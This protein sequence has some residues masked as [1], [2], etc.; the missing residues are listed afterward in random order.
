M[1]TKLFLVS[2]FLTIL[3]YAQIP[4]N[5]LVAQYNFDSGATLADGINGTNLTQTGNT[6]TTVTD[7]FGNANGAVSL[8]GAYLTRPDINFDRKVSYSF[9]IK[10]TTV[11]GKQKTIIDNGERTGTSATVSYATHQLGH[12]IALKNGRIEVEANIKQT[13]HAHH[14]LS[15]LNNTFIA[16]GLWHHVVVS[17]RASPFTSSSIVFVYI[18]IDGVMKSDSK[19]ITSVPQGVIDGTNGKISIGT[20]RTNTLT[21]D[22]IYT[23]AIDDINIYNEVLDN[24]DIQDLFLNNNF[25]APPNN[26][27]LTFSNITQNEAKLHFSTG[28]SATYDV[29]YHKASEPFT[30]AI[31]VT[32]VTTGNLPITNLTKN[33]LYKIYI[34]KR[35]TVN[36]SDWSAPKDLR[37]NA[38]VVYVNN[39]A[40][41]NNDGTSWADAFTNLQAALNIVNENSEIWV[42]KGVYKPAISDK[43]ASYTVNKENIKIYGGFTGTENHRWERVR[44]ANETILSGDLNNNDVNT[45]DYAT[46]YSNTTRLE[47]SRHIITIANGGENLLL[48]GLTISNAHNNGNITIQ[49]GAIV[50]DKT[51]A[52]LTLK[53]C[54][55]KNNVSGNG[56]AGVLAEFELNN[57]TGSRGELHIEN[58]QFINN[59]SRWGS[60]IY[61]F[62]RDDTR[63][64]V[65][66]ANS[67]F[68][69]N[70]AGNTTTNILGL[71]GSVAWIRNMGNAN[72]EMNINFTNNTVVKNIDI[73]T[74]NSLS[75]TTRATVALSKNSV[76]AGKS[77]AYVNNNIFWGNTVEGGVIGRSVT[78]L[79]ESPLNVLEIFNSIDQA[80]FNDDSITI[81]G[82]TAD[83]DPLFTDFTNG[84]YTLTSVAPVINMGNNG[85]VIG[86]V[87]LLGNQRIFDTYVDIGCYEYGAPTLSINDPIIEKAIVVYP[88]P[89]SEV[90]YIKAKSIAAIRV[91]SI[92]GKEVI[93]TKQAEIP[94]SNLKPGIYII[95]I[96]TKNGKRQTNR[97]IKK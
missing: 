18:A 36:I 3:T 97:F 26:S 53:N 11:S 96:Q 62:L 50:K 67:L 54:I 31:I 57:T 70:I 5:G 12:H 69:K 76:T 16:D 65:T 45:S 6:L 84:D 38:E 87:D 13:P 95:T 61:C 25:C 55:I 48:D 80:D 71:A 86:T 89:V 85:S 47:N 66:I 46:N 2:L 9:W 52:K 39:L 10:T 73:G 88:N 75:N 64:D 29:A 94:V 32:N 82:T 8:N 23:D 14:Y 63:V 19:N 83:I 78:D 35:C 1:K 44:G 17:L 74:N 79:H 24:T 42:A 4:T 60:G 93:T 28:T 49:G 22:Y 21:N 20:N 40:I 91:Y 33:T 92:L 15:F 68:E 51:I 59:M 7:R 30:N 58:S 90:L 34:R 41:G 77:N 43:E 37:T 56:N 81:K 27:V 72:S